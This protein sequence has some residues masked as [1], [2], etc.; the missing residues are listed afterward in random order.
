MSNPKPLSES[1]A[2]MARIVE[3]LIDVLMNRGLIQFT[4]LPEAAQSKLLARRQSRAELTNRLTLL[5]E[6]DDQTFGL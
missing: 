4:D 6:N 5:G 3:D 2:D 1:D